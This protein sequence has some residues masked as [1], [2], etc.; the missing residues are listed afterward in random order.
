MGMDMLVCETGTLG[1]VLTGSPQDLGG[2]RIT[3]GM[4]SVA[5]KQPV[6]WLVPEPAPL[7]AQRIEQ[8]GAEHDV[9]VL[10]TFPP[11]MWMT[12]RWLSIS[13]IFRCATSAATC[14][15]GI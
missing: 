6:R 13:L 7:D 8:L 9:A 15:R 14:A 10:A 12:I 11:R 2:D 5:G 4:P 1:G 3:C